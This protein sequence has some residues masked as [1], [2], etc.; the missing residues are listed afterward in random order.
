[1]RLPHYFLTL[2]T[3]LFC[4]S[5]SA[6][7]KL[8]DAEE[9]IE[10]F[11]VGVLANH[12]VKKGIERWQMTMDYLSEQV[13]GTHFEVVPV[14]FDEMSRQLLSHEIQFIVTNPGQYLNL[15]G[16]FPLSWLATMKS[17]KHQQTT[18][19]I[20][21][22]IIV[23]A[24]S[25][26]YTL[27]DLEGKHIVASDPQA[28]GGYQAAIGL[29]HKVGYNPE[30]FFGSMRFLGFPLEPIVYQVRDKTVD[31]AITPFC[32]LE[33]MIDQGMVN[34][35]DFRVIHPTKPEGCDCL[36]STQLYPNWSFASADTVSPLITQKIAQALYDLPADHIAAITAKNSGWTAPISQFKVI[37]LFKEL[38]L[39]MPP[40]P[41]H[42]TVLKW[43]ERNKEWGFALL[44]LFVAS[45]IY[46][47]WLE[48]KFREK[49]EYL[50]ETER[51]LKDKALQV[52]RM[53]SAAIL[54]E[55]GSGLAHE[56]NQPIAAI[57]QYSE[58]GMMRLNNRGDGGSELYELLAKINAQ[59]VRAGAVVHRIRG[60]LKRR[61]THAEA[62]NISDVINNSLV[63]FR[64]E[65]DRQNIALAQETHGV[66]YS[67]QGDEVGLSQVLVNVIKNSLDAMSAMATADKQICVFLDFEDTQVRVRVRDNGPGL[68]G[69]AS[70]LMASFCSTK[71]EGLGLGLAICKDVINQHNGEFKIENNNK[72]KESTWAQGCVVTIL[73]PREINQRNKHEFEVELP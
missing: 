39:K 73:L 48:Y 4:I 3:L 41:L 44:L 20:G 38:Q 53:Q 1:M 27:K 40:P 30:R 68:Q 23:R 51:Q 37:Q 32:T 52:E 67:I 63:L 50:L 65:F 2:F 69:E 33:E 57:T 61:K 56:L 19:A 22:T 72:S 21:S 34:K 29:L 45:T 28:L 31:A 36:V 42:K 16:H 58:G 64:R 60:L 71:D 12:G 46:H 70:E 18:F 62:L 59:S 7:P 24:D 43:M 5:A 13:P 54:G 17:L 10:R 49:S 11:K 47:L 35:A 25:Q 66:F 6:Q 15:S 9:N 55:I 8:I 26:I 14:D